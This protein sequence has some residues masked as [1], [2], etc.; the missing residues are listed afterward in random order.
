MEKHKV[1]KNTNSFNLLAYQREITKAYNNVKSWYKQK[2]GNNLETYLQ[3][4][5]LFAG[6]ES[7]ANNALREIWLGRL[8]SDKLAIIAGML[9]EV[10][11]VLQRDV[12][13]ELVE[14]VVVFRDT[15]VQQLESAMAI[16][17][18]SPASL[19]LPIEAES[20]EDL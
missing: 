9:A 13:E 19:I 6:L 12:E 5:R 16:K 4:I 18:M 8:P 10:S 15:V 11:L 17:S 7:R 14:R 2:S 20:Q 3:S 1:E